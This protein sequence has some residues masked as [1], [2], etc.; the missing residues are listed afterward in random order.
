MRERILLWPISASC[1]GKNKGQQHLRFQIFLQAE[2]SPRQRI[3]QVYAVL[4]Y[5]LRPRQ[6]FLS[7]SV[8]LSTLTSNW[9]CRR[10]SEKLLS[11]QYAAQVGGPCE[12]S[13]GNPVNSEC[14]TPPPP[15]RAL[16]S[17]FA[18]R[19]NSPSLF[20]SSAWYQKS[21]EDFLVLALLIPPWKLRQKF[22]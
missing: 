4:A 10:S 7:L 18:P 19:V 13:F 17:L 21:S 22:Y 9:I 1:H 20:P 14:S 16:R 6:L 8:I 15:P 11:C 12:C 3:H 5:P 2:H